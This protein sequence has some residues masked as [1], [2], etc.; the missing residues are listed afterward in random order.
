MLDWLMG[1]SV[2]SVTHRI[3]C[4][5]EDNRQLHNRGKPDCRTGVIAG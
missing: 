2:F 4:K 1:R 5:G 3:M